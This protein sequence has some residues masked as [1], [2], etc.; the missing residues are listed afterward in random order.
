MYDTA[1]TERS[2]DNG[3]QLY[4]TNQIRR[5]QNFHLWTFDTGVVFTLVFV[6]FNLRPCHIQIA[7]TGCFRTGAG[8][9]RV[10]LYC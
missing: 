4:C 3:Q 10:G 7:I 1:I 9:E 8:K 6:L 5:V 2:Y